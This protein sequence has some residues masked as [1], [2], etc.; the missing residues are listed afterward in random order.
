MTRSRAMTVIVLTLGMAMA[1]F[2]NC[3]DVGFSPAPEDVANLNTNNINNDTNSNINTNN[4]TSI[5]DQDAQNLIDQI[6]LDELNNPR[7][8]TDLLTDPGLYDRY[9]CPDSDGVVICHFPDN[10]EAQVTQCIGRAAAQTH[11][12]HI[13]TYIKD[14]VEKQ[15]SDYLG[16]CRIA[17]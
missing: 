5:S 16:P 11:F 3:S 8:I 9:K 10:V 17:L 15:I 1:S 12:D 14:N 4:D 7:P 6:P 13:R 2:N